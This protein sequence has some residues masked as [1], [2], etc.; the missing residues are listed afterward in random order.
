MGHDFFIF[1]FCVEFGGM[2]FEGNGFDRFNF[3][4]VE[5]LALIIE[6][7]IFGEWLS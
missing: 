4:H 1:G 6:F 2:L 5:G 3:L 7:L